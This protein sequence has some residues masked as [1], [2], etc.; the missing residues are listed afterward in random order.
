ME[1]LSH[2]LSFRGASSAQRPQA[3]PRATSKPKGGL[4]RMRYNAQ[5]SERG[6]TRTHELGL[7]QEAA[8]KAAAA[9]QALA[10]REA[11]LEAMT[12]RSRE[13][14]RVTFLPASM[15]ATIEHPGLLEE[16]EEEPVEAAPA[17]Q[18]MAQPQTNEEGDATEEPLDGRQQKLLAA[19][20]VR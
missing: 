12:H 20:L 14:A 3:S 16:E 6:K 10:A 1:P 8:E 15:D 5:L 11:A 2:P 9:R 7:A 13:A 4:G 19:L 18:P 17:L